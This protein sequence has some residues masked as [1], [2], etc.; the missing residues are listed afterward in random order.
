MIITIGFLIFFKTLLKALKPGAR[1]GK[2][3]LSERNLS[4]FSGPPL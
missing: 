1:E 3:G 4:S 2:S